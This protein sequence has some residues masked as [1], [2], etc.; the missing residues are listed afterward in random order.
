MAERATIF[1][2]VQIGVEATP[3][4]AVA[5]NK[6]LEALSIEPAAQVDIDKFRPM[7][8][9]FPTLTQIGKDWVEAG[10]SGVASY[11]DL[12]YVFSSLLVATTV[13][14]LGGVPAAKSW[15]FDPDSDGPDTSKTYTVEHG[16]GRA[17]KFTYGLVNE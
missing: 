14:D 8:N 17:D 2:T 4:T 11:S 1:Q 7:G 6:K 9:K 12:T 15:T 5:A 3:G 16:D 13:S 10:L